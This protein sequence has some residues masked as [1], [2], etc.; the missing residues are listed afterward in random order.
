[1][2]YLWFV[3]LFFVVLIPLVLAITIPI[4]KEHSQTTKNAINYSVDMRKFVYKV[5]MSKQEILDTLSRN[6]VIDE[7]SCALDL[8]RST[9]K[10][11]EY[12]SSRKYSF[13]IQEY[14]GFSILRLSQNS[15]I[16]MQSHIPYKLNPFLIKKLN[17]QIVPFAAYRF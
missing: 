14:E 16:E 5:S 12:D 17:A 15:L 9:I 13:E 2:E 7:L 10:F 1:M 11:S 4:Y 8:E 6:S 3:V